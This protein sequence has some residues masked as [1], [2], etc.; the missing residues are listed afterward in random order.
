MLLGLSV[1]EVDCELTLD[2]HEE[3]KSPDAVSKFDLWVYNK[4]PFSATFLY[5]HFVNLIQKI[6]QIYHISELFLIT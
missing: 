4:N 2:L 3:R 6:N 5:R 1:D